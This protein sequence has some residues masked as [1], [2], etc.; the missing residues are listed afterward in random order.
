M[1]PPPK[2]CE[3]LPPFLSY[4]VVLSALCPD[5]PPFYPCC[6]SC[7]TYLA[8]LLCC[9]QPSWV[10]DWERPYTNNLF[11][12]SLTLCI[13]LAIFPSCRW[14][15]GRTS[16]SV[17]CQRLE[18]DGR[19]GA[20][21][22]RESESARGNFVLSFM[23]SETRVHHFKISCKLG[24]YNIGGSIWFS[25]LQN[26]VGYHMKYSSVVEKHSERLEFPIPPPN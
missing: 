24:R 6:Y 1:K 12:L 19:A 21:L 14:F 4:L 11:I 26:L 5:K 22:I 25:S 18:E 17:A 2:I 16:R 9:K 7:G 8:S 10:E 15:H 23:D 20:Y 13:K 3:F